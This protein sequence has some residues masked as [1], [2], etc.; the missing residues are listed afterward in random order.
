MYCF[1]FKQ[2]AFFFLE[3]DTDRRDV[4]F[5]VDSSTRTGSEGLANIRD[6]IIKVIGNF[7]VE[8]NKVRVG[9][10]Q[11]SNDPTTEFFLK[12]HT[13]KQALIN[14]VRRLRLKGG[15][16]LNIGKALDFVAKNHFVKSA[17]SRIEEQVPQHLVLLTGGKSV[18][19]VSGA[20]RILGTNRV[21]SLAVATSGADRTEIETIVS[22]PRYLFTIKEFKELPNIESILFRSFTGPI[23]P[24]PPPVVGPVPRK[25]C[26]ISFSFFPAMLLKM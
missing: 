16:S 17:G 8:P 14:T 10:V 1:I 21:K 2:L 11:F 5:L 20:A 18:D 23:D 12:T 19:D 26:L 25:C 22:D 6:F 3:T 9:L 4:V 13:N 15:T 24:S 7:Q